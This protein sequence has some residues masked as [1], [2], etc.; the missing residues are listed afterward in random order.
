[1]E[2]I[3]NVDQWFLEMTFKDLIML[4]LTLE[5]CFSVLQIV[6]F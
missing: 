3:L 2:I 4:F 5:V 6:Q 1:M